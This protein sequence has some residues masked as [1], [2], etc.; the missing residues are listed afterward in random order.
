MEEDDELTEGDEGDG[1]DDDVTS[2]TCD[3]HEPKPQKGKNQTL[4]PQ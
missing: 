1:T 4:D 3:E 2:D